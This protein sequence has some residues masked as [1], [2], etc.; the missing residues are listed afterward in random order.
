M[1]AHRNLLWWFGAAAAFAGLALVVAA[2]QQQGALPAA[3][4]GAYEAG[5]L[6]VIAQPAPSAPPTGPVYGVGPYPLY[7]PDL[8]PGDGRDFVQSYCSLC[9]STVYITMQPPR[10][11]AAWDVTVQKMI[12]AFG[13]PIPDAIAHKITD[14]L[15]AHYS[16]DT[17]VR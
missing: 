15:A 5:R 11:R 1:Q 7:T 3:Q 8:A 12:Q 16:P 4:A 2:A 9:H 10:P 13:A 14:Y 6:G 17:R